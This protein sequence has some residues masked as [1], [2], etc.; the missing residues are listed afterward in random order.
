MFAI[1]VSHTVAAIMRQRAA[2]DGDSSGGGA[3]ARKGG[4]EPE[5]LDSQEQEAMIA[6]FEKQHRESFR[7][8]KI[9]I[10]LLLLAYALFMVHGVINLVVSPWSQR[11]N[12]E[13]RQI[14]DFNTL[15]AADVASVAASALLL[16]SLWLHG[17]TRHLLFT[18]S[19]ALSAALAL[20]W[21][22]TLLQ[23]AT[24]F[25]WRL[26]WLPLTNPVF[27]L[28]AVYIHHSFSSVER[29]IAK[30]RVLKYDHKR[31]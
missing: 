2:M 16:A 7:F 13:L 1:I 24:P 27:V 11:R 20:F 15:A 26:F 29:E 10:S 23:L 21:C 14:L 30:L 6:T 28:L 18:S 25:R 8:W 19:A 31:V 3:A 9:C 12:A 5:F 22:Y 4:E 17:S